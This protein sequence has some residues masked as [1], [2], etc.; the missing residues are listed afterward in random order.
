MRPLFILLLVALSGCATRPGSNSMEWNL[1]NA[2]PSGTPAPT[3][4]NGQLIL[5]GRAV[6]SS[7]TYTVPVTIEC[8][9]QP[10]QADTNSTFYIDLVPEGQLPN[11]L[12][13]DYLGIKLVHGQ[14]LRAW[15][16]R[17]NQPTP[18]IKPVTVSADG[19]GGY[20]LTVDVQRD[21]LAVQVN[22]KTVKVDTAMPFNEFHIELRSFP[23]PSSWHVRDFSIR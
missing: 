3:I 14:E 13:N 1:V 19:D 2:H 15:V 7:R 21:S 18:L 6:R 16:S 17:G 4:E 11:A 8:R 12:P 10:Q 5:S 9:L 22:G 23:P 20:K